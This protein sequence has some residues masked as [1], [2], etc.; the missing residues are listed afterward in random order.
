MV[1]AQD[2]AM[3]SQRRRA[4]VVK[5]FSLVTICLKMVVKTIIGSSED[6][7]RFRPW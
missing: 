3:Q 6:F 1:D 7:V 4:Y 2:Y 5:N